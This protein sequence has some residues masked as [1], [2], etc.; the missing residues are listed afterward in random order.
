MGLEGKLQKWVDAGLIEPAQK[1]GILS[2]ERTRHASTWKHGM[3]MAGLLSILLGIALVI[4]ANWQL[5]PWQLKLGTHFAVNAV[6]TALIWRWRHDPAKDTHREVAVF[7]LWGLTLTLIALMGQVFQLDGH[8]YMAL[9]VWFWLT[10]PMILLFAQSRFI[11]KLWALLFVVYVPY[12]LIAATWD[13]TDDWVVRKGVLVATGVVLPLLAWSLG[14]LPRFAVNRPTMAYTLRHLAVLVALL[15]ASAASIE[16]YISRA[17]GYMPL[18]PA[19]L[20]LAAIAARFVMLP[21]AHNDDD[22]RTIDLICMAGLFMCV[23]FLVAVKSDIL[24]VVHFIAFWALAGALWQQQDRPKQVSTAITMITLRLFVGFVELFG[25]MM[26]SG[27]GF[28]IGGVVMI[29]LVKLAR[30]LDRWLKREQAA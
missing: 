14:S 11:A 20:A 10:T 27:F 24:A 16:F 15:G 9:R 13:L 17:A 23:P 29:A 12:D 30:H 19:M 22:R 28:I 5:I 7:T 8:A 1:Q 2:H 4:A 6:L 18:I 21:R 25:S 26:F 3:G